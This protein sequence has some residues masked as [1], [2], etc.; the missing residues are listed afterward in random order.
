MGLY[1][2]ATDEN[3]NG[4]HITLYFLRCA[5]TLLFLAV[6]FLRSS[7]KEVSSKDRQLHEGAYIHDHDGTITNQRMRSTFKKMTK[8]GVFLTY[9]TLVNICFQ[10]TGHSFS[11]RNVI[12][13]LR[14]P[15]TIKN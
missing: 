15:C 14:E 6:S 13:G 12:F 5:P 8:C 4:S 7:S 9:I 3:D 1:I 10:A 2:F 11:P